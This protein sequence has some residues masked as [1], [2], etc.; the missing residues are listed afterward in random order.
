MDRRWDDAGIKCGA[1]CLRRIE[2]SRIAEVF[3]RFFSGLAIALPRRFRPLRHVRVAV[4][5]ASVSPGAALHPQLAPA[6]MSL[7]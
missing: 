7:G 3:F 6:V 1:C 2:P 5:V 4:G